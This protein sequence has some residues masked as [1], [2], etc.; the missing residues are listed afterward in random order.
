[1]KDVPPKI[2]ARPAAARWT[3]IILAAT[4]LVTAAT[5]FFFN[6][7]THQ[8]YP[9]CTLHKLT[10]L[11]C[12]GCGMTR[13]FYALLHGNFAT[14]LRDNALFVLMLAILAGRAGW[15]AWAK[16]GGRATGEF[17]PVKFLWPLLGVAVVFAV[18][19]NLPAFGFLS[20]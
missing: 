20:P 3:G 11:N 18:L 5:F 14:A 8:F 7:A 17:F 16:M 12:P 10:G 13:A 2:S 1:M 9:I 15:F 19:R 4:T 6:P